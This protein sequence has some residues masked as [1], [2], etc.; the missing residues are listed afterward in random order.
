MRSTVIAPTQ[1]V[2]TILCQNPGWA[3]LGL[4]LGKFYHHKV[5]NAPLI[6]VSVYSPIVRLDKNR[7]LCACS[8]DR[9]K[10]LLRDLET[11]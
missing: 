3:A 4:G 10:L 7:P 8:A 2:V 1:D 5:R 11:P 6:G 9:S